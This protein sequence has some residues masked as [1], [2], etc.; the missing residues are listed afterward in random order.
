MDFPEFLALMARSM[1]TEDIADEV[2][3]AFH[4]FDKEGNGFISSA[5]LRHVMQ[6]LG[7]R[8]TNE[9]IDEMI[10][11]ADTVEDGQI[12]YEGG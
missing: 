4:V 5:E 7:E 9:E 3:E 1:S 2:K 11:T 10:Q 12:N 8:L 6:H